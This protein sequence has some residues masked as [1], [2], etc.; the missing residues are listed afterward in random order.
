MALWGTGYE[1]A[2]AYLEIEHRGKRLQGFWTEPGGAQQPIKQAVTEAM[3]GGFTLH[4]TMV[5]ENRAYLDQPPR[6]RPL[7]QQEV[8]RHLGAFRFEAPA[9]PEGDVD[10]GGHRPGR[11]EGGGRNGG[12]PLRPSLDAYLP[13]DW[14]A[15]LRRLPPGLLEL[16]SQFENMF[17]HFQHCWAT[18]RWR[19]GRAA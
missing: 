2:R 6:R 17:K 11:Q 19:E 7:E 12:R 8:D 13:H 16:Q 15:G 9:R 5:R 14:P 4:V 10:G 18:G 1:Q 3:R